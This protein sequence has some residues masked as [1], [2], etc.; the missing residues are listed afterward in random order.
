MKF[1]LKPDKELAV[2]QRRASEHVLAFCVQEFTPIEPQA[3]TEDSF[4]RPNEL[5]FISSPSAVKSR[6][7]FLY[8]HAMEYVLDPSR[9]EEPKPFIPRL[10]GFVAIRPKSDR[11]DIMG[12]TAN[13]ND[14]GFAYYK[15]VYERFDNGLKKPLYGARTK[16][17]KYMAKR[18]V[19][20]GFEEMRRDYIDQPAGQ[21]VYLDGVVRPIETSDT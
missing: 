19:R 5:L 7:G 6:L 11:V 17:A 16:F 21:R 12:H 2:V 14:M 10:I 9:K 18:V 15:S 4:Y 3:H 13:R 1:G 8:P 20:Q